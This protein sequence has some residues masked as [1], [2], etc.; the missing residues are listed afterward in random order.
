MNPLLVGFGDG[1][2]EG[3]CAMVYAVWP[4][5]AG[6]AEVFL[7]MAK[8]RVSPLGGTTTVPRME[9][10]SAAL[11]SRLALLVARV[12]GFTPVEIVMAL[13]S[14]CSVSAL[15]RYKGLLKPYFA[16]RAAEVNEAVKE[17]QNLCPSVNPMVAIP[18]E[19][20]PADIGTRSR[21]TEV[22]I[23]PTSRWQ[24][25]PEFLQL[26]RRKWP[27]KTSSCADALPQS[28]RKAHS[29][30]CS[31]ASMILP[32]GSTQGH[33][34]AAPLPVNHQAVQS[35]LTRRLLLAAGRAQ[36][37]TNSLAKATRILA[38]E[39]KAIV[40]SQ[41]SLILVQPAAAELAA[42]T[43]LLYLSA[44]PAS[45]LA[46]KRGQLQSL[47]VF[48]PAGEVWIRG[49]ASEENIAAALGVREL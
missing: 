10:S 16:H 5:P 46:L 31:L 14:E 28:E 13:D 30:L 29:V 33:L 6:G 36:S 40:L 23:S 39:A 47:G 26:P 37:Y 9:I 44:A 7:V 2:L 24:C 32:G 17:L 20:N 19:E 22:D 34:P 11:L 38:R 25:G 4:R 42:A 43:S 8:S 1:S 49:R 12:C 35:S 21:A 15:T 3:F 18:G 48:R 27:T 45:L 41:R